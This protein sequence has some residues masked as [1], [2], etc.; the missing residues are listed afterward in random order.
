M[1]NKKRSWFNI[2]SVSAIALAG[3]LLLIFLSG[4]IYNHNLPTVTAAVPR[5][6]HLNKV[7]LTTGIVQYADTVELH[8]DMSGTVSAILVR[9]GD[10]VTQGQPIMEMDFR[11][12]DEDIAERIEEAQA[13]LEDQQSNLRINRSRLQVDIERGTSNIGNT[14]RQI[15]ELRREVDRSD[16][17]SDFELRQTEADIERAEDDLLRMRQLAD[18]G[19]ATMQE[20]RHVENHLSTLQDRRDHQ[21]HL[22]DENVERNREQLADRGENRERQIRSLEHQLDMLRQDQQARSLDMEAIALQEEILQR[23]FEIRIEGYQSRLDDYNRHSIVTAPVDGVVTNLSISQGQHIQGHQRLASFGLTDN[24]I[25]EC[26]IPLSN[27]FVRAGSTAVL[28]NASHVL[29][30]IVTMVNPHEHAK[31]VTLSI[32]S[33]TV[34]AGE[35]F[36]IQF[37][38]VSGESFVLVPNGAVNRDG[39]GYF[40]NQIRRRRG[41]LGTEFY[42][43]RLRIYIGDSDGENT[44]VIGGITFFEPIALVSDRSFN[45]RETIRLRNESDF[46]EN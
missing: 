26:E 8:S 42:T 4:T 6:G 38:E 44:A 33:D 28:Y 46:F 27:N 18:A 17:V 7:E 3:L 31:R 5:R 12:A 35:T 30:G 10:T 40:V 1:E 19:I 15:D 9:E 45:E 20:L 43:T 23:D 2:K 32:E 22:Y 14:Q 37:E 13:Q 39:S 41:I 34:T 29:E 25:V 11:G 36:T 21:Q 16:M 24:F